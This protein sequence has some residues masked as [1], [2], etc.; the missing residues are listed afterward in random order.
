MRP[1]PRLV[2]LLALWLA[3]ALGAAFLEVLLNIWIGFGTVILLV[4][5]VE[6][7]ALRRRPTPRCE[8][9]LPT[10]L[11]LGEWHSITIRL[12]HDGRLPM[13]VDVFD[14]YPVDCELEG[15]P[16]RV[17]IPADGWGESEDTHSRQHAGRAVSGKEAVLR[18]PAQPLLG[19]YF[20]DTR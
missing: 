16:Q 2:V 10:A 17:L 7:I 19:D 1:T 18:A 13:A 20:H 12:E 11:S 14:G 8:R 3:L 4:T 5:A 6:A 15:Q 9:V